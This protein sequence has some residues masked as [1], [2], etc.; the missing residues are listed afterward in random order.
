MPPTPDYQLPPGHCLKLE[1]PLYGLR[2]SPRSWQMS[3]L[4]KPCILKPRLYHTVFEGARM[5]LTLHVDDVI[6]A[7]TNHEYVFE[8]KGMFCKN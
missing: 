6:I 8:V 7:F 3:L 2:S 5:Y 4:F 1:K